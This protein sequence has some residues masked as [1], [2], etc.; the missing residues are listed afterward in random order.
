MEKSVLNIIE[1]KKV[2]NKCNLKKILYGDDVHINIY[3]INMGNDNN[4]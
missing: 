1:I 2:V 4:S 3:E